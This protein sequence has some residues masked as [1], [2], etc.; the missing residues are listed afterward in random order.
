[1]KLNILFKDGTFK[2]NCTLKS[3]GLKS[4]YDLQFKSKSE[5]MSKEEHTFLKHHNLKPT[6]FNVGNLRYYGFIQIPDG[7]VKYL[8]NIREVD[9]NEKWKDDIIKHL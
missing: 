7:M 4:L 9:I 5:G 1:M 8:K 2:R 3:L 6:V